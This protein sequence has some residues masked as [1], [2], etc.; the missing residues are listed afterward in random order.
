[1][2][3]E[4]HFSH[5]REL[6]EMVLMCACVRVC[7]WTDR[8]IAYHDY[9]SVRVFVRLCV[10]IGV[11]GLGGGEVGVLAESTFIV[12]LNFCWSFYIFLWL[13]SQCN[14]VKSRSSCLSC[15]SVW[16]FSVV[17]C[18]WV[19]LLVICFQPTCQPSYQFSHF[20][21]LLHLGSVECGWVWLSV[22]PHHP[23]C[24]PS[25]QFFCIT[26]LSFV[27]LV[28]FG[29]MWLSVVVGGT[30]S[31]NLSTESCVS[32][33]CLFLVFGCLVKCGCQ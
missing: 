9:L 2:I 18:G 6:I 33:T 26:F 22:V 30:P 12:L 13:A 25:S 14:K 20:F 24:Q 23:C 19:W 17:E 4:C 11:W 31:S 32:L 7:V 3:F 29:R 1:M 10:M 21:C 8:G 15:G 28:G 16:P 27:Y 5:C